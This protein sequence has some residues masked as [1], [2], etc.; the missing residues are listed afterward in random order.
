[1]YAKVDKHSLKIVREVDYTYSI[2]Y[3]AKKLPKIP[4]FKRKPLFFQN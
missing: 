3:S 2:P 4:K 1:M